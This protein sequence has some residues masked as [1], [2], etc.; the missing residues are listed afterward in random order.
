MSWITR[1]ET[2]TVDGVV[3]PLFAIFYFL[4]TGFSFNSITAGQPF[5]RW[6]AFAVMSCGG[7]WLL[8][9]VFHWREYKNMPLLWLWAAFLISYGISSLL[10]ASYGIVGNGK[11]MI[12]MALEFFLLFP[13]GKN[14]T[15]GEKL[16]AE[17][18]FYGTVIF[19]TAVQALISLG[20]LAVGYQGVS[21]ERGMYLGVQL[22]RLW[23]SY[24]DPNYG[25]ILSAASIL[26]SLWMMKQVQRGR[27]IWLFNLV[28]QYLYIAF[29][30]S[31]SGQICLAAAGIFTYLA[32][33]PNIGGAKWKKALLGLI[34]LLVLLPGIYVVREGYNR[35]HLTVYA[36]EE[37]KAAL[38]REEELKEDFSNGRFAIWKD[39]W[40]VFQ[41]NPIFGISYRNIAPYMEENFPDA[42]MVTKENSLNTFHNMWVDVAVSQGAVGFLLLLGAVICL[43][44]RCIAMLRDWRESEFFTRAFPYLMVGT[45]GIGAL[46][47]S[48]IFYVNT[49]TAVI[50]WFCLGRCF[51][52]ERV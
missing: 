9:R 25:A 31:R 8:W 5:M 14:R 44:K 52:R 15:A 23:G 32:V 21:V 22:G 28:L 48:D 6:M 43:G 24:S 49:P 18:I 26:C 11:A 13:M 20:M 46:F 29:S 40:H 35:T 12:W 7:V 33:W 16:A 45:I 39:G 3:H 2:R 47:V 50:F 27:A 4:L 1:N 10:T 38:H 34:L 42:Y 41:K 37:E 19:Y 51:F 36:A 30:Y 17:K